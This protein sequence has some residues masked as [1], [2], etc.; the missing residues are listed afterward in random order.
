MI[1]I[2]PI[3]QTFKYNLQN[4]GMGE[5]ENL[6]QIQ[7]KYT[8]IPP[9][10]PTSIYPSAPSMPIST[11]MTMQQ[12]TR[13]PPVPYNYNY[14]A[15]SGNLMTT[16]HFEILKSKLDSLQLELVDLLR[17]VK[18]YTQRY[19][20]AIRQQDMEKIDQYINGLFQVDKAMKETQQ[21]AEE[22]RLVAEAAEGAGE[23]EESTTKE[24]VLGRATSGITSFFGGLG[25]NVS[26]LTGFVSDTAGM[27]NS[28]LSKKLIGPS[29]NAAPTEA[30]KVALN[31]N[32]LSVDEYISNMNQMNG[33]SNK[34]I[35]M[36]NPN[37]VT[38]SMN[39]INKPTNTT[40]NNTTNNTKINVSKPKPSTSPMKQDEDLSQALLQL[41]EEIN[42]DIETTVNKNQPTQPK[43]EI[44]T[45]GNRN[46][47]RLTRKIK[48][49]RLKL[50][51]KRL[52]KQLEEEKTKNNN[53]T[54][55]KKQFVNIKRLNVNKTKRKHK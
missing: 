19:M 52:Q 1:K 28:F 54:S 31:K 40:T 24:G 45:G 41:N 9:T 51:K 20:N 10:A 18:D 8:G 42:K 22:A 3:L 15:T 12:Q 49:L 11:P 29:S 5:M 25:D 46:E 37:V 34:P 4:P 47:N 26:K 50:T 16:T 21:R 35:N 48:M 53:T 44:Q 33:T 14:D 7:Q 30:S 36:T 17:H 13:I 39:N 43:E 38:S 27:A 2:K 32:E 23:E 55:K 6:N